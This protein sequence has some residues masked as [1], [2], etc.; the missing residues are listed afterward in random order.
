MRS[1]KRRAVKCIRRRG[2]VIIQDNSFVMNT[3]IW[4]DIYAIG[5]TVAGARMTD[6]VAWKVHLS[7]FTRNFYRELMTIHEKINLP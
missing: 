2:D 3:N 6:K 1:M 7:L 4:E 5:G